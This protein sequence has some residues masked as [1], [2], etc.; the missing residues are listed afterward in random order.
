MTVI[1][2]SCQKPE[3][4]TNQQIKSV[5]SISKHR[6]EYGFT[7]NAMLDFYFQQIKQNPE[8]FFS[9]YTNS[10]YV[11][12]FFNRIKPFTELYISNNFAQYDANLRTTFIAS[13]NREMLGISF[14]ELTSQELKNY[15]A[16][17]KR[18]IYEESTSTIY[19]NKLNDLKTQYLSLINNPIEIECILSSISV[20]K[21]SKIYWETNTQKW[22]DL[23]EENHIISNHAQKASRNDII[24]ADAVGAGSGAWR[25]ASFGAGVG[26]GG[27]VAGGMIGFLAGAASGS[28]SEYGIGRLKDWLV[29]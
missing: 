17:L 23:F 21:Y 6:L 27:A 26:P 25:G 13:L 24:W 9:G 8:Q 5:N 22:S 2:F 20:A 18:I 4:Y 15:F 28:I 10:N 1:L 3:E 12:L 29:F 16:E 7:H 19:E 14:L 11:S